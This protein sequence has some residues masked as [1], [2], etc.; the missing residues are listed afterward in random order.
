MRVED[1]EVRLK[2]DIL[3][4]ARIWGNRVLVVHENEDL[5]LYDHWEVSHIVL[6]LIATSHCYMSAVHEKSM[7]AIRF[8]R[9]ASCTVC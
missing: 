5:S 3:A 1:M 9:Q 4:E 7:G 2:A 6:L 8:E